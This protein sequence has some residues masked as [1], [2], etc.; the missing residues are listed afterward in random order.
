M[1]QLK[2]IAKID[3]TIHILGNLIES[4]PGKELYKSLHKPLTFGL[5]ACGLISGETK[6]RDSEKAPEHL[7]GEVD[8]IARLI[9]EG[10]IEPAF[11]QQ[12]ITLLEKLQTLT[13]D[14]L[15]SLDDSD[16]KQIVF[17]Q[18]M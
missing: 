4:I 7:K 15:S 16:Q 11:K 5:F 14:Y 12:V 8:K 10:T 3:S 18:N 2:T 13:C 1:A 6:V 17:K 9:N